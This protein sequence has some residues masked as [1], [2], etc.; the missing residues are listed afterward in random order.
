ML[1]KSYALFALG[2]R[3]NLGLYFQGKEVLTLEGWGKENVA[4]SPK[5]T[6]LISWRA[7]AIHAH[8]RWFGAQVKLWRRQ[9]CLLLCIL[10]WETLFST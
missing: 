10:K 7:V 2:H 1:A 8:A 6:I 3:K 4:M 5:Q 9:L